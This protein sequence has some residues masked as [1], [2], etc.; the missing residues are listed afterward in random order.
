MAGTDTGLEPVVDQT[1]KLAE[2]MASSQ[3]S[4]EGM[5]VSFKNMLLALGGMDAAK[6]AVESILDRTNLMKAAKQAINVESMTH[7]LL[8]E[9]HL[10]KIKSIDA[11]VQQTKQAGKLHTSEGQKLL[12]ILAAQHK[13]Y[14]AQLRFNQ[15]YVKF[16][17]V[18]LALTAAAVSLTTQLFFKQRQFNQ[19]L[20][21]ANSSWEHRGSLLRQTLMMQTQLGVGFEKATQAV[22]A[23]V[24]F[25]M[26][27][28]SSFEENVR[29]VAQMDQGL[30]I[31]VVQSAQLASIVERQLHGSFVKVSHVL[32]QI[33]DDTALAGD[34]AARLAT[35]IATT[36]GRLRPGLG[37][38]G[39]PEVVRLVGRYEGALKEVS[40]QSGAFQQLLEHLTTSEGMTGA[41][42]LGVNPEFY[43]TAGGVDMVMK[44]FAAYGEML[45]GQSAGW[46]RQMRLEALAQQFNVSATQA[47]QMLA[48]IKRA[49]QQQMGAI[50]LQDRWR[51][52]LHA[53]DQGIERITNSLVGL[54]QQ[55]FYP[56]VFAVGTVINWVA[57]LVEGIL[58]Y[59]DVVTVLAVGVGVSALVLAVRAVRLAV[60][61]YTTVTATSAAIVA[62]GRLNAT[63][64]NTAAAAAVS[65]AAGAAGGVAGGAARA[66]AA[67]GA[68]Y[69]TPTLLRVMIPISRGLTSLSI[70][71]G[72]MAAAAAAVPTV[73]M[74]IYRVNKRA[75]DDSAAAQKIIISR[76][77]ALVAQ[78]KAAL[79]SAARYG[80]ADDV[81]KIYQRLARDST[82]MFAEEANP[83]VRA[84]KQREWL[85][86]QM[87][88]S[89]LDVAKAVVSGG[90]FDKLTERTPEQVKREDE[91]MAMDAK[92]LKVNEEQRNLI[93]QRARDKLDEVQ[94]E[95][96]ER[97]KLR[98]WQPSFYIDYWSRLGQ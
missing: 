28:E 58:K 37:A 79:Y 95:V 35:S 39:L 64:I 23:L 51:N 44:R 12:D 14:D 1:H 59:R 80:T 30:G 70:S 10:S 16:G 68:T 88:E 27:T 25:G 76:Q 50:T 71:L 22:K 4:A 94:E 54:V 43:A 24:H 62:L 57:D 72:L 85:A 13:E 5:T 48:A 52:Q 45:V 55:A 7:N 2:H 47:N 92:M 74:L 84:A 63:L 61:L 38:A 75:A 73:L 77:E 18:R 8:T 60:S 19:D 29:L 66:A 40:G 69:A 97:A 11:L 86:Q 34:E 41:G 56:V 81:A 33:V 96:L 82:N 53:T 31:A 98:A 78:R 3:K 9:R 89:K 87:E 20:I 32:A 21:E 83:H 67:G 26:D 6:K 93:Y 17:K 15:E 36:L 90:M 91:K 46:E 42:A 65:N 49:N